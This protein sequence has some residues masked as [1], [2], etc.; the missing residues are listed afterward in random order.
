MYPR[1]GQTGPR[2]DRW[3]HIVEQPGA[4]VQLTRRYNVPFHVPYFAVSSSKLFLAIFQQLP[5]NEPNK[6][7]CKNRYAP[8]PLQEERRRRI[9]IPGVFF[10]TLPNNSKF[11]K[12]NKIK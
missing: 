2:R 6:E 9:R 10:S 5:E 4:Q 7:R 3:Q 11:A 12:K 8:K 1:H